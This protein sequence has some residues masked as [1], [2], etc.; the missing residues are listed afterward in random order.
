MSIEWSIFDHCTV[1]YCPCGLRSLAEV[2]GDRFVRGIML[3]TG[4]T[5]VPFG[6][7]LYAVPLSVLWS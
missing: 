3:H 7:E 2:A 6:K 4:D 1:K 5:M